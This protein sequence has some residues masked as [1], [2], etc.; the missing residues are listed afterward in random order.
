MENNKR[1]VNSILFLLIIIFFIIFGLFI[2]FSL[3]PKKSDSNKKS[4][5]VTP[6]DFPVNFPGSKNRGSSSLPISPSSTTLSITPIPESRFTG[7]KEE[8]IDPE[9]VKKANQ[10]FELIKETP[11]VLDNLK[12][13]YDF[14]TENFVVSPQSGIFAFT[15]EEREKIYQWFE[16]NYPD[17]P[18]NRIIFYSTPYLQPTPIPRQK[19]VSPVYPSPPTSSPSTN[20]EIKT[21]FDFVFNILRV[22]SDISNNQSAGN[23]NNLNQE[24]TLPVL[25]YQ[26]PQTQ[27]PYVYYPQ[28]D[29]PFDHYPLPGGC[30]ICKAG[31]GPTTASMIIASYKDNTID[32]RHI[33][34]EYGSA[35]GCGGSGYTTARRVLGQYNIKVGEPFL[36]NIRGVRADEVASIFK[37]H[38]NTGKTIFV[39]A[40]FARGGH[41]FWVIDVDNDN[42]IWSFDPY[43][44]RRQVPY[45]QNSLYPY[46]LYRIAF[47]VS[48]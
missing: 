28:C 16:K 39:L 24:Q 37:K 30:T 48:P 9:L 14:K 3:R 2:V 1:I 40:N 25:N 10:V 27:Y 29:G 47:T 43:Y 15:Q 21:S 19:V 7:V 8:P 34:N 41:Y 13:D 20:N 11:V 18:R 5:T 36:V 31:C 22:I 23:Q 44:G 38:I 12:I 17:I 4:T 35:V 32:P 45:N 46:P 26:S 33:V 42:N 6:T